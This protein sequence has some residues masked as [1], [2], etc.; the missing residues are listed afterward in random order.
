MPVDIGGGIPFGI[1]ELLSQGQR[2]LEAHALLDH[3]GEHEVG[4]AVEDTGDLIHLVGREALVDRAQDRDAAAHARLEQE[5]EVAVFRD[6]Q[7]LV[8]LGR[9][10]FLV[11]GDDAFAR[12]QA[13]FDEFIGRMEAAHGLHHDADIRVVQDI[14]E[15]LSE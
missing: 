4:G 14:V 2:V 5:V 8:P 1:A 10:Q 3:L 13:A 6:L 12:L 9:H 11:G 15:I 7:Q